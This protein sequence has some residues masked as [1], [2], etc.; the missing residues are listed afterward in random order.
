MSVL[1]LHASQTKAR[2]A[3]AADCLLPHPVLGE[4]PARLPVP[5]PRMLVA[6]VCSNE[7]AHRGHGA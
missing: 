2:M 1:G 3:I 5:I 4:L 7:A 6:Q